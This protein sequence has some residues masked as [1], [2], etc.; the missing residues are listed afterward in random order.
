ERLKE[1][2]RGNSDKKIVLVNN[3][4][5]LEGI[6][7][8]KPIDDSFGFDAKS[9]LII[10]VSSFRYPKDQNTIIRALSILPERFKLLSVGIG[11]LMKESEELATSLGLLSRVR[12]LGTRMDV[13]DL[14]KRADYI[15][16]SSAHEGLSL[17]SI[18]GLASG[19][20]FIASNVPGL[21]EI[22]EGA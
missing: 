5:D 3:G 8:A 12:F 2:L 15:V 6:L 18:E 20:P 19:T 4:I 1:H 16:L 10:Q 21:T 17:S 9:R 13:P 7:Q 14:L 11:E 22:V